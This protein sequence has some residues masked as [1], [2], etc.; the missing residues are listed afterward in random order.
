M[1]LNYTTDKND[2][3]SR[4]AIVPAI[5]RAVSVRLDKISIPF[6]WYSIN[7]HNNVFVFTESGTTYTITIAPGNYTAVSL[8]SAIKSLIAATA[9]VL[10]YDVS[11]DDNT[12][13]FTI[14]A[15]GNFII[16]GGSTA[17]TAHVP[18]GFATTTI[19][20]SSHTSD[21][22]VILTTRCVYVRSNKLGGQYFQGNQSNIVARVPVDVSRYE[23]LNYRNK[24]LSY[25]SPQS[26]ISRFDLYITDESGNVLDLNG[27]SFDF[28]LNIPGWQ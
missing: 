8:A 16:N 20:A 14:S 15:G 24:E 13:K 9:A 27:A 3:T 11:F 17:F 10:T 7:S 26:S 23:V 19:A 1:L 25:E 2:S 28:S 18:T 22:V 4:F 5:N 6:T 12:G 21:N